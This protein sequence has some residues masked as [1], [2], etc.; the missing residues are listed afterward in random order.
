MLKKI[1]IV[2]LFIPFISNAQRGGK[3]NFNGDFSKLG[4]KSKTEYFRGN[5]SGKI[6]DNNTGNGLEYANIS[7]INVKWDKI[8]EGTISGS[9]GKFSISGIL[10]GDYVL[11]I[12][13]IGYKTKEVGFQITKRNPDINLKDISLEISSEVLSEITINEEK[14]VYESKIDKIIYNAES[15]DSGASEDATDVLRKAPLLSVDFDGNVELRG[16]KQIKFLFLQ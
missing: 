16:S 8:I 12:N 10:I 6:I 1:F 2:L 15:D 4:K 14:P 13:Y 9:N 11:K 5:I 7:L 3:N